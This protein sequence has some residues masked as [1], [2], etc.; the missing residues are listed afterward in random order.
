MSDIRIVVK[1]FALTLMVL[2][3]LWS[4]YLITV[5]VFV[6][7]HDIAHEQKESQEKSDE[8]LREE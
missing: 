8:L 4:S 5:N 7:L 6:Y 3:S 2:L 1:A